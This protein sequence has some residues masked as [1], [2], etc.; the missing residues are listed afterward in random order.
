LA[1][2][3]AVTML[4]NALRNLLRL[5]RLT[6]PDP[7]GTGAQAHDIADEILATIRGESDLT[8]TTRTRRTDR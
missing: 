3:V 7:A 5:L 2:L 6:F 8:R 4:A 1:N